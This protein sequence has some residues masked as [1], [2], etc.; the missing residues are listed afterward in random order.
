[1][2]TAMPKGSQGLEVPLALNGTALLVIVQYY[3]PCESAL[4]ICQEGSQRQ[5]AAMLS[6]A[7]LDI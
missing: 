5:S 1:M 6:Q 3:P 2:M 7:I 4:A